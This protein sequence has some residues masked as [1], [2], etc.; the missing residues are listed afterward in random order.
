MTEGKQLAK[1]IL[2]KFYDAS[3]HLLKKA[4]GHI[5]LTIFV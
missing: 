2:F 3:S 1:I 5:M 4:E